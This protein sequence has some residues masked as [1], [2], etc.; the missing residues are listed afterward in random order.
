MRST[1][2]Q[3]QFQK[4]GFKK[5]ATTTNLTTMATAPAEFLLQLPCKIL[6]WEISSQ[7]WQGG[8]KGTI[9]LVSFD[10]HEKTQ[11]VFKPRGEEATAMWYVDDVAEL[12]GG[13]RVKIHE[14]LLVQRHLDGTRS[15]VFG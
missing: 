10:N 1:N 15:V 11:V 9:F 5:Q 2:N 13:M 3:P 7:K 8:K 12:K 6:F 14:A 4:E